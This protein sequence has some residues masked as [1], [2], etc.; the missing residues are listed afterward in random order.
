M[1]LIDYNFLDESYINL[2]QPTSIIFLTHYFKNRAFNR[3][4]VIKR[5]SYI[6]IQNTGH[7]LTQNKQTITYLISVQ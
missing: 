4:K 6:N 1:L 2:H 3:L 5:E 7:N